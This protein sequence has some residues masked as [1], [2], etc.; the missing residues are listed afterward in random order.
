MNHF[1]SE[2]KNC[3]ATEP[4]CNENNRNLAKEL[5]V[6]AN[7]GINLRE[8]TEHLYCTL[9]GG[10]NGMESD[11]CDPAKSFSDQL[12]MHVDTL[13]KTC[14]LMERILTMVGT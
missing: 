4:V 10:T 3:I 12:D 7:A 2:Q 1:G 8:M 5:V 13:C 9:F 11:G 6:A 14:E